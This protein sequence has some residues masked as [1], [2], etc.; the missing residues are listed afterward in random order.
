M[1]ESSETFEQELVLAT[2]HSGVEDLATKSLYCTVF[3]GNTISQKSK[4]N[5]ADAKKILHMARRVASR[6][7]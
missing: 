3:I 6:S 4:V 5:F 2:E 1:W 7:G